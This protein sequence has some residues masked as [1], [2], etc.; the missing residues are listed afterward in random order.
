[1]AEWVAFVYEGWG[2][3]M[4]RFRQGASEV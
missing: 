1:V 2:G 4:L 3:A